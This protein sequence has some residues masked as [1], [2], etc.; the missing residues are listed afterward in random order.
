[1]GTGEQGHRRTTVR[2]ATHCPGTSHSHVHQIGLHLPSATRARSRTSGPPSLRPPPSGEVGFVSVAAVTALLLS[3]SCACHRYRGIVCYASG[4]LG[5]AL[6]VRMQPT[7]ETT[8]G[9]VVLVDPPAM[10]SCRMITIDRTS[11][12][13]CERRSR[14]RNEVARPSVMKGVG[15][16]SG[17]E[18]LS[19][20][21]SQVVTRR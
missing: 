5:V 20:P 19:R 11:G 15:T 10:P 21:S 12:N 6:A 14:Q 9:G 8:W 2:L 17:P 16:I 4:H 3:A 7:N 13:D 18:T 1:R